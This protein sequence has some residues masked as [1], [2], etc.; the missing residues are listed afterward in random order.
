MSYPVPP[1]AD[2]VRRR[3]LRKEAAV[4][5]ASGSLGVQLIEGLKSRASTARWVGIALIVA[6]V[7]AMASPLASGLSV[8][9]VIGVLMLL[10]GISSAL[11]AFGVGAFGRGLPLLLLAVLMAAAGWLIVTRP[12][13]AL[14]SVTLLLAFY[15]FLSG[16]VEIAAALGAAGAPGR[17][18]MLVSGIV[19]LL[20]GV[21]LWRH[22]PAS[23]AV[24]VGVLF[25][26]RM[27]FHGMWLFSVGLA[28]GR[29]GDR[30][31]T[32]VK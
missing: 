14:A 15:F 5:N 31:A 7:L 24:A 6:G 21:S 4:S 10:T 2:R 28:A 19:T 11:L 32:A 25:G 12:V 23:A 29:A 30:I 3:C 8:M 20:L 27:L 16:I 1:V 13:E 18:W 17:G 9:L 26:L 22:F